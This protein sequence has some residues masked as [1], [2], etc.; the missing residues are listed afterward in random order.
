MVN[1]AFKSYVKVGLELFLKHLMLNG[2]FQTNAKEG[3][4]G[5]GK[6]KLNDVFRDM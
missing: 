4:G 6:W 2:S 3:W 1:G 5:I